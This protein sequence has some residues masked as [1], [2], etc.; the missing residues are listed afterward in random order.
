[1]SYTELSTSAS[2]EEPEP[3]P[4]RQSS[5]VI[6][7]CISAIF[8]IFALVLLSATTSLVP[9]SGQSAQSRQC[10]ST[11]SE[12]KAKGCIFDPITYAWLPERCYDHKLADEW[13]KQN[14]KLYANRYGNVTKTEEEFGDDLSPSSFDHLSTLET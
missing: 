1:M 12:A 13:R 10:G 4:P 2:Q 8:A 5:R 11:P 7:I 6:Y 14:F 9:K 3:K